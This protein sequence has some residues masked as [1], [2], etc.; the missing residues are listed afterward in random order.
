VQS[1]CEVRLVCNL[2]IHFASNSTLPT[3]G[4]LK[5]I[6]LKHAFLQTDHLEYEAKHFLLTKTHLIL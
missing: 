2:R 6:Y 4:A 5:Y 3:G 1:I